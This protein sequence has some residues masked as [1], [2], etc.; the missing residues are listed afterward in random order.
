MMERVAASVRALST[1]PRG[2]VPRP[3]HRVTFLGPDPAAVTAFVR[4][5]F[6]ARAD[7]HVALL[8]AGADFEGPGAADASVGADAPDDALRLGAAHVRAG[9]R[10]GGRAQWEICIPRSLRVRAGDPRSWRLSSDIIVVVW[11]FARLGADSEADAEARFQIQNSLG[12][13]MH[14]GRLAR[15]AFVVSDCPAGEEPR[16]HGQ[17]RLDL[18]GGPTVREAVRSELQLAV[19]RPGD[20]LADPRWRDVLE[21]K[22]L[23][24]GR[25][26]SLVESTR[27]AL[28]RDGPLFFAGAGGETYA[29]A[30]L[31]WIR[32]PRPA[33]PCAGRGLARGAVASAAIACASAVLLLVGVP[34]SRPERLPAYLPLPKLVQRGHARLDRYDA[35]FGVEAALAGTGNR[36]RLAR[37][38]DAEEF[39]VEVRSQAA[40]LAQCLERFERS[41]DSARA[42]VRAARS[43]QLSII[44]LGVQRDLDEWVARHPNVGSAAPLLRPWNA[45]IARAWLDVAFYAM[46]PCD[47]GF[48]GFELS[49]GTRSAVGR[50]LDAAGAAAA[51]QWLDELTGAP[52][53]LG[54]Y[55]VWTHLR[56]SVRETTLVSQV[57]RTVPRMFLRADDA[58]D[59]GLGLARWRQLSRALGPAAAAEFL[60]GARAD[61]VVA[62]STAGGH[63]APGQAAAG[64]SVMDL[65]FSSNDPGAW[66]VD[67]SVN[68]ATFLT[69]RPFGAGGSRLHLQRGEPG[70]TILFSL[71][72]VRSAHVVAGDNPLVRCQP[73]EL[74][75]VLLFSPFEGDVAFAGGFVLHYRATFA[76]DGAV[77]QASGVQP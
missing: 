3:R 52:D 43:G 5:L 1:K 22:L 7:G 75:K 77:A 46:V 17:A 16:D 21:Q 42:E 53:A 13:A 4:T 18:D 31:D 12:Q 60:R 10:P 20:P 35:W 68:G 47:R 55:R 2:S 14:T 33:T 40:R 23:A 63:P 25:L 41:A 6:R 65:Q 30:L 76:G 61:E 9:R 51:S 49:P 64:P 15:V 26:L 8:P 74:R 36:E 73:S 48:R 32:D 28:R 39:G 50:G 38:L 69:A 29:D 59:Q 66:H 72:R 37:A 34:G 27:S 71:N 19:M 62:M 57:G 67:V 70:M 24:D 44:A 58:A 11:P 54:F 45:Q 56:A